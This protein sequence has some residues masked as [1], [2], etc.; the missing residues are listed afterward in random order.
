MKN[1]EIK[2][3]KMEVPAGIEMNDRDYLNSILELEKNMSNNYSI[4]LNEASNDYLYEDY[5][6]LLE[7]SKDAAREAYNLMFQYG[8]YT[9][10]EAEEQKVN[11]KI[12]YFI[13]ELNELGINEETE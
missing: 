5:F 7:D 1:N 11:D 3:P 4:A 10:E 2:N 6:T 9:L 8:W 12:N 13:K